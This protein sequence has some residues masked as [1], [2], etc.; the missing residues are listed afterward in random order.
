MAREGQAQLAVYVKQPVMDGLRNYIKGSGSTLTAAIEKAI[1]LLLAGAQCSNRQFSRLG[2]FGS[3]G[4]PIR[5]GCAGR[6]PSRAS[7]G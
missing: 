2:Q 5:G 1:G 3:A 6:W 7:P 4:H